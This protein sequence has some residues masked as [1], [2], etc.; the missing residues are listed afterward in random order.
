[1][2]SLKRIITMILAVAVMLSSMGIVAL[3]ETSFSDIED[4]NVASA[5]N[6]LVGYN[7]ITGYEDGT[8]KPQ[9]EIT[10]AEFAAIVTRMKG[11]ADSVPAGV[12][13]GFSDLDNDESR[14]WARPYVKA[15]VDLG[16]VNGF[17][18]GTF[19]AGEP[20]T[21][22]Q[23]VKMLVCA[24]G[25]EIVAQS[26]MNK[27]KLTNPDATWSA[28]YIAAAQKHGITKGAVTAEI[29]KPALRGVVAVLTSNSY[30]VPKLESSENGNGDI[31]YEQ[32]GATVGQ[33]QYNT[34]EEIKGIVSG[35]CYTT[36][37]GE[38]ANIELNQ[39][40][41]T[42]GTEKKIYDLTRELRDSMNPEDLIGKRV[43]AYFSK[44]EYAIVKID[45]KNNEII[46]VNEQNVVRPLSGSNVK[47][48][49]ENG[50]TKTANVS[51]YT[52]IYNGKAGVISDLDTLNSS[53]DNGTI[54]INNTTKTIKVSSYEVGVVHSYTAASGTSPAKIRFKYG[55]ADYPVPNDAVVYVD[56][57]KVDSDS[58][59]LAQYN[60]VNIL[61]SAPN[62]PGRA[63]KKIFV[64]KKSATGEITQQNGIDREVIFTE[65]SNEKTYCLTNQYDNFQ[66]DANDDKALFD[67]GE[68]FTYYFDYIG[69]IAAVKQ[70]ESQYNYGY[71][72]SVV[73][74]SSDAWVVTIVSAS[75]G[76]AIPYTVTKNVKIDGETVNSTR[77]ES[78]LKASKTAISNSYSNTSDVAQP[79]RYSVDG[80]K[81]K[82]IDTLTTVSTGSSDS[83]SRM[84][85]GGADSTVSK[86]NIKQNGTN[87][88]MLSTQTKALYVPD[89]VTDTY[90]YSSLAL[91]TALAETKT[92]RVEAFDVGSDNIAKFVIVYGAV[93][94]S[95]M[96]TVKS[97]YMI[98]S[99]KSFVGDSLELRGYADASTTET[100]VEVHPDYY[101]GA[102]VTGAITDYSSVDKGDLI[103]YITRKVT[104][105]GQTKTYVVAIEKWFDASNPAQ[106][107]DYVDSDT[108]LRSENKWTS[109]DSG[110]RYFSYGLVCRVSADT[111]LLN[112]SKYIPTDSVSADEKDSTGNGKYF[113]CGSSKIY[114]LDSDGNVTTGAALDNINAYNKNDNTGDLAIIVS[115]AYADETAATIV[116]VIK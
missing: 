104:E 8:F 56:G 81:L 25:Y 5:V 54:E 3:A 22:E 93:D 37:S 53:F 33:D 107:A 86:S 63:L 51:G 98:V 108:P 47:Y 46:T 96:F 102:Y 57:R 62:T 55:K 42:V 66:G 43:S 6:K 16:V 82:T 39:I 41:L 18:D 59:T 90:S 28:G 83:F 84:I 34:Q 40:E 58:M 44:D 103:R 61:E 73:E 15:A 76:T 52:F 88:S 20:V 114:V 65:G 17:E 49:D 31:I 4:E 85:N 87:C 80:S 77:I 24:I 35:T 89:D 13:T 27:I 78:V 74:N 92:R 9:N 10:R 94:P 70:S 12:K 69:Q 14:A 21:Y 67:K 11:V 71:I 112:L 2:K 60:V 111:K 68:R 30:D 116:Y 100:K 99:G 72:S 106:N 45:V 48:Y 105:N 29:T 36:L 79:V 26:E 101:K 64:T 110:S 75:T 109:A 115:S 7:V 91:S 23:A 32:G 97:T 95:H 19:R 1:M 113:K 50:R 38:T